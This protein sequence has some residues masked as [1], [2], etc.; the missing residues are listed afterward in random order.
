LQDE[1]TL[2]ADPGVL[3]GALREA[4]RAWLRGRLPVPF[5][6]VSGEDLWYLFAD[7][8]LRDAAAR[9]LARDPGARLYACAAIRLRAAHAQLATVRD[10]V[11][12]AALHEFVLWCQRRASFTLEDGGF[13]IEAA[14]LIDP[15]LYE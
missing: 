15:E 14:D 2:T 6:E 3:S 7:A 9:R 8:A 4:A 11:T 13:A 1:Y 10:P 5:I 12:D